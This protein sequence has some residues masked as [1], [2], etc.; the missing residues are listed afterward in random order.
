M[1]PD[2]T[3]YSYG[4][5]YDPTACNGIDAFGRPNFHLAP[6]GAFPRC[7]NEWGLFD[8][9]GNLWEQIAGGTDMTVRGGAYNCSDSA[10][11][12]RCRYPSGSFTPSARG[13]R[14]CLTPAATEP[15]SGAEEQG[16]QDGA[17]GGDGGS[18]AGD[19]QAS[20]PS[21]SDAP[22]TEPDADS[23]P[24]GDSGPSPSDTAGD[25]GGCPDDMVPSAAAC[26]DRYEASRPDATA[27][28][29]GV[30][31]SH[32]T[33]RPGV[34]PWYVN[35]M[36]AEALQQ[37]A[38]ACSAAGKRLCT[39]GEWLDSCEGP[40]GTTYAF[41]NSFDPLTCNSVD[42]YCQT[43]CDILGDV[44]SCPTG[45]NCGYSAELSTSP[46]TPE[47][48]FITAEYGRSSCHVCFH[49]MPTG[50]FAECTDA[51]GA[52]DV[53][54]NVWEAVPVSTSVDARG[55]QVRGGAFNCGNPTQRFRCDFNATWSAL[56]AGFRCCR[57]RGP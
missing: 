33:S 27:T 13:F 8:I 34:L 46:Y 48:C 17:P 39:A 3:V 1:G 56:Y 49:V 12:H 36:S 26:V 45:G 6:T 9:N 11:L 18:C 47:T 24:E 43:C 32:A 16:M 53:N 37:F 28:S 10:S 57:D 44:P 21:A 23:G 19:E 15:D 25:P 42:S 55:Y 22:T 41:G 35:P 30:D 29:A 50:S 51:Y 14:C 52:Y 31:N 54:G 5:T 4:D 40:A 38:I 2:D 20:N 7:T